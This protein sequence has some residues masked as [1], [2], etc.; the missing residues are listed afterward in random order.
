MSP[1]RG[2]ENSTAYPSGMHKNARE[3]STRAL[4]GHPKGFPHV[5]PRLA[6]FA[7]TWVT[8]QYNAGGNPDVCAR[9]Q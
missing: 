9:V 2:A 5:G 7:R 3:Q 6:S 1:P 4:L 8:N